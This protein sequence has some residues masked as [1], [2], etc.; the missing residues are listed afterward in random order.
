MSFSRILVPVEYSEHCL[1]ALELAGVLAE[2]LG[3]TL[4]VLHVWEY[5]HFIPKD[6]LVE[7]GGKAK[8]S[9]FQL[10]SESATREMNAFVRRA[11]LPRG[12]SVDTALVSGDPARVILN[13][14]V[15]HPVDLVVMS[16]H[17]RSGFRRFLM[18]SVAENVVRLSPVPVLTVPPK[19]GRTR[20]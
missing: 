2:R 7:E 8:R 6:V 1:A 10:L 12:V 19:E 5:P 18:G 15:E 14:L 11:K 20:S 3:G 17:G 16:T 13:E 4:K 9:L